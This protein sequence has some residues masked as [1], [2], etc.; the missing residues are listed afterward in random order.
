MNRTT[1]FLSEGALNGL[2]LLSEETGRSH[3]DLIREAVQ[4]YLKR[5]LL[6][7]ERHHSENRRSSHRSDH[8]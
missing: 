7:D 4:Q 8:H 5:E 2:D 6:R 1:I 3:A